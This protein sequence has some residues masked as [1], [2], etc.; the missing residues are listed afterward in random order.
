MARRERARY[1]YDPAAPWPAHAPFQSRPV[2][3]LPDLAE[4]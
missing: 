1:W 2:G 3:S 4:L